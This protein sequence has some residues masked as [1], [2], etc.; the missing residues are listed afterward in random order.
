MFEDSRSPTMNAPLATYTLRVARHRGFELQSTEEG[1]DAENE[2][3][4]RRS[5]SATN[6]RVLTARAV[7]LDPH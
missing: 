6:V 7:V 4:Q 2:D 3:P 5:S 1:E